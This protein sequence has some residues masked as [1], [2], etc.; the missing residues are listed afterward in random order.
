MTLP[1]RQPASRTLQSK[2][3][4]V[5]LVLRDGSEVEGGIFLNP[6][7]ALA[8]YLGSRKGGW[9][10]LVEATWILP[11]EA[12]VAHAVLQADH[13]MYA[14]GVGT[15]VPVHSVAGGAIS[16]RSIEVTLTNDTRIR[17]DLAIADRQRLSDFLHTSG[18]FIP[19]VGAIR[20]DTGQNVGDI[21]LNHS[22]VRVLHDTGPR[23]RETPMGTPHVGTP[24]V[25]TKPGMMP[26]AKPLTGG[27][28]AGSDAPPR[29]RASLSTGMP[30]VPG[31]EAAA[32]RAVSR[33]P[34]R[35]PEAQYLLETPAPV[36]GERRE[37]ERR[38]QLRPSLRLDLSD[39]SDSPI[40]EFDPGEIEGPYS[41]PVN[42]LAARAARHWLSLLAERY[43]LAPADP[44]RL[45]PAVT[46]EELWIGIARANDLGLDELAV[47]IGASF[48]LPV[49]RLD[50]IEQAAV[51]RLDGTIA[52]KHTVC[53]VRIDDRWLVVACSDPTDR[54]LEPVLRTATGRAIAFEVAPAEA[55]RGAIDWWYRN[56][57]AR[58]AGPSATT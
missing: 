12:K 44:R 52:R 20:T 6:G 16:V 55:I 34:I 51:A 54:E 4:L 1:P 22:A 5:H 17:G 10:N 58:S 48:R 43:G 30:A 29:P 33:T 27:P 57:P 11:A 9:V 24:V 26:Q 45:S 40:E 42:A 18:K 2:P 23:G 8:P 37:G 14:Y 47:H 15:D 41:A 13:V 32:G 53:P 35:G 49:A 7:Q 31:A 46:T 56:P 25:G 36:Q 39:E 19:I 38:E 50:R 28:A 21:A 3:R